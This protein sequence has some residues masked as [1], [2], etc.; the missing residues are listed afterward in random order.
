MVN[1]I[2]ELA[3]MS[4]NEKVFKWALRNDFYIDENWQSDVFIVVAENGHIKVLGL[5]DRK[6][7]HWYHRKLLVGAAA[8]NDWELLDFLLNKKLN[9]FDLSF[10]TMCARDGFIEVL[11]WWKQMELIEL[12]LMLHVMDNGVC[13]IVC[14]RMDINKHPLI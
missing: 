7:L 9:E 4:G 6:E 5:A 12:F 1:R 2:R 8:R 14:K 11:E 3:A 13:W 10:T